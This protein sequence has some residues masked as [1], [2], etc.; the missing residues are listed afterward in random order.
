M[1]NNRELA[2]LL[3]DQISDYMERNNHLTD[4]E[5]LGIHWIA[6]LNLSGFL[7]SRL[8]K[9]EKYGDEQTYDLVDQF[10]NGIKESIRKNKFKENNEPPKE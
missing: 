1:I 2:D 4:Q 7:I 8:A 5:K 6:L 10:A 3:F 9:A